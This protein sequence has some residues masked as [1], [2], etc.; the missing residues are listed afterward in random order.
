MAE[1]TMSREDINAKLTS[2]ISILRRMEGGEGSSQPVASLVSFGL[3]GSGPPIHPVPVCFTEAA[4]PQL[5]ELLSGGLLAQFCWGPGFRDSPQL[6]PGFTFAFVPLPQ[7]PVPDLGASFQPDPDRL[8]SASQPE[9]FFFPSPRCPRTEDESAQ[10]PP[11]ALQAGF[12]LCP[13]PQF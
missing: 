4:P 3:T 12:G 1:D 11:P 5:L 7:P 2:S 10:S 8:L 9:A 13:S 6:V